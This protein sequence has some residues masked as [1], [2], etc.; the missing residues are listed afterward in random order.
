MKIDFPFFFLSSYICVIIS[1]VQI[2][3]RSTAHFKYISLGKV[4]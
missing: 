2:D 1:I 4:S 3:C